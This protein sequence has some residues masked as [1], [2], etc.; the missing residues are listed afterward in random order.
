MK[1]FGI[2]VDDVQKKLFQ[3]ELPEEFV[4]RVSRETKAYV[5]GIF[6]LY[7]LY[8]LHNLYVLYVIYIIYLFI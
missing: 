4:T 2:Q 1:G 5:N 3:G 6:N 7:N 8:N